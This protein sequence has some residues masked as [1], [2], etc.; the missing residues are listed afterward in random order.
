MLSDHEMFP[1]IK[2]KLASWSL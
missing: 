2:C 1:S